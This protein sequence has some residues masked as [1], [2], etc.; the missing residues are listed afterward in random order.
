MLDVPLAA[1]AAKR[2]DQVPEVADANKRH[3]S[4]PFPLQNAISEDSMTGY[5]PPAPMASAGPE[6]KVEAVPPCHPAI[7]IAFMLFI[8][9]V[10]PFAMARLI[11][12][13]QEHSSQGQQYQTPS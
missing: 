6:C 7:M 11:V 3:P 4:H 2:L 8:V 1:V 10:F 13:P 12:R 9:F 5:P